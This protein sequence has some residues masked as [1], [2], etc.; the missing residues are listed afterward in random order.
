[1][2]TAGMSGIAKFSGQHL[3]RYWR[4]VLTVGPIAIALFYLT[5]MLG[6]Q[7]DLAKLHEDSERRLAVLSAALF[8]PVDKFSYLP[9]VVA[10]S[11]VLSNAL[12]TPKNSAAIA[13]ANQF[14]S[15]LNGSAKAA[16]VY[17]LD[18]KGVAI[19]SSNWQQGDSFVGKD[20]S[21]RPYF[22]QAL[23]RGSGKFY[24]MGTTS[25]LPG[26]YVSGAVLD[27]TMVTGVVVVKVDMS[28]FDTG[29]KLRDQMAI[30]DAN[31]IIFLSSISDW[32]YRPLRALS[33]DTLAQL[34]R[35]RQYENVLRTALDA[36]VL[37][38]LA[39][40][41][42]LVRISLPASRGHPPMPTTYFAKSAQLPGS[43]WRVNVFTPIDDI[44][45]RAS[46]TA[47][48]VLGVLAFFG[49][50]FL[51]IRQVQA[52]LYD[53]EMSR[54]AL[55]AAHENLGQKHL[56]LQAISEKLQI[57]SA[58]DPLTGAYNRRYFFDTIEKLL[59]SQRSPDASLSLIMT[60]IDFFKKIND[61]YG[62][63]IG[64]QVLKSFTALAKSLLRDADLF[65]RFGGEEFLIALPNA[66]QADAVAIAQ[67]LCEQVRT[68]ALGEANDPIV[69][70]ISCGVAQYAAGDS[71]IDAVIKRA[72]VALYQ[73]KQRGRNRVVAAD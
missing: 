45:A 12:A 33:S 4:I 7:A 66:T 29:W 23:E 55:E 60:D 16:V 69:V 65:V 5:F 9:Q 62:H 11:P 2:Q 3:L 24:G 46:W 73:A 32:K 48:I 70:T 14:L 68:T 61:Q 67:R 47:A 57:T 44:D 37:K 72:D 20:Y 36:E 17:L 59:Y 56:E 35:T 26:Y 49:I 15:T 54:R 22:K 52:N 38:D 53:R 64:D 34:R 27:G 40:G 63:P 18:R 13:Q 21:F 8:G 31:G 71:D 50:I 28:S 51:Y 58:T 42:Q 10:A 6:R 25:L 30:T 19:A 41:E 39:P 43:D 1:M